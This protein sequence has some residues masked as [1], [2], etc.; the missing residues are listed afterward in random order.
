MALQYVVKNIVC[1]S[2]ER[3]ALLVDTAT[4]TPLF[5]VTAYALTEVRGRNRASA[6]IEQ[7]LRSLKV[8]LLFCD[9]H[10]ISLD[11]RLQ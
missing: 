4:G 5:D 10:D 3:L 8:L 9:L 1:Q 11:A 7:V 2:G 6:T